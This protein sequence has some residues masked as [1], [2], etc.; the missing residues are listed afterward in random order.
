MWCGMAAQGNHVDGTVRA[1]LKP[2]PTVA[3][4]IVAPV[5]ARTIA[6]H[7][8][9]S[10][11]QRQTDTSVNSAKRRQNNL[12]SLYYC[13]N[14]RHRRGG[15][16]TRPNHHRARRHPHHR[17]L[18]N[19]LLCLPSESPSGYSDYAIGSSGRNS[20]APRTKIAHGPRIPRTVCQPRILGI[21]RCLI[22][23]PSVRMCAGE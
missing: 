5:V 18:C 12:V 23:K 6:T 19:W 17:R 7:H 13:D 9:G 2:A 14:G 11:H 15:F 21:K 1:G 8:A 3:P 10:W 4:P 20:C 22:K 16:Q